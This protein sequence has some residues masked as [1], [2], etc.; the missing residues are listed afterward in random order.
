MEGTPAT[1]RHAPLLMAV[2]QAELG[3]ASADDILDFELQLADT[4]PAA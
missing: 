3:L 1:A 2:I 4:Q